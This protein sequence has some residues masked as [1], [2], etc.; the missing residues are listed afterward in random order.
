MKWAVFLAVGLFASTTAAAATDYDCLLGDVYT[1]GPDKDGNVVAMPIQFGGGLGEGSWRFTLRRDEKEAEIVWR[2]SPMQ[3][4]GKSL[5]IPTSE[6]SFAAFYI[7]RGPCLF[8]EAHCGTTLHFAE[9]SDGTLKIRLYPIALT[10]F[11]DGHR[12]PFTIYLSGTCEPKGD[13]K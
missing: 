7:G 12:E 11:E 13:D 4:S 9:Q 5:L 8:T 2:N 1:V 6:D 10:S 3:L